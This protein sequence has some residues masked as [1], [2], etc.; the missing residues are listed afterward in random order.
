[1]KNKLYQ[2]DKETLENP[3]PNGTSFPHSLDL[4]S[5]KFAVTLK[6]LSFLISWS[7][8]PFHNVFVAIFYMIYFLWMICLC[9]LFTLYWFLLYFYVKTTFEDVFPAEATS[10]EEY[11]QQVVFCLQKGPLRIWHRFSLSPL[12]LLSCFYCFNLDY[13]K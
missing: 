7:T 4:V 11:L 13:L 12:G 5:I 8:L 6:L 9:S 3:Y 2:I 10:V 1:M